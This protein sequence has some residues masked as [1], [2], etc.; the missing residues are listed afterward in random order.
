MDALPVTP[1]I[2]QLSTVISQATAPAFLLGALSGFIAILI[3]RLNRILDRTTSIRSATVT[4]P[5]R[6]KLAEDMPRLK[7][8]A[9]MINR[10]IFW[11]VASSIATAVL[12]IVAFFIAFFNLPHEYGVG[13]LF[14]V[15]L[16]TFTVALVDLAREVRMAVMDLDH[17]G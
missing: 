2:T 6:A 12:L 8:R 11:A 1:T 17:F 9:A 14:V 13:I 16:S 3:G 15:A 10:A 7:R 4:D 5:V